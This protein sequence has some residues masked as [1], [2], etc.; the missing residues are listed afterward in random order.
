M[1]GFKKL[2]KSYFNK[3]S[4][5]PV[6]IIEYD[7]KTKLVARQYIDK[8]EGLLNGFPAEIM[9]RGSTAFGIAGKGDIEIGVYPIQWKETVKLLK[10]HYGKVDNEEENYARFN[11]NYKG[12][13]IEVI[14]MRGHDAEVDK[15]LTEHLKNS[16]VMLKK[17]ENLKRKYSYSKKEYMIKKNDFF[18]KLAEK[19]E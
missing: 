16:P 3:Y 12:F 2:P 1:R 18:E 9:H 7:P 8:L 10:D 4:D 19:L 5:K 15:K 14:L 6:I 17:Y 11:D 13:E